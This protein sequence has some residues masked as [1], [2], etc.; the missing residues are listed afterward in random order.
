[1]T[2]KLKLKIGRVRNA[3]IIIPIN[4]PAWARD[5]GMLVSNGH[6]CITSNIVPNIQMMSAELVIP[7]D[8]DINKNFVSCYEFRNEKEAKQWVANISNL[9]KDANSM[10]SED[11][12]DEPMENDVLWDIVY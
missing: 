9:I 5:S 7:R 1:M 12:N 10:Y 3:V 11:T 8:F 6:Y 2:N 4:V